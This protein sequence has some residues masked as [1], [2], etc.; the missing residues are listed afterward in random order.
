[1]IAIVCVPAWGSKWASLALGLWWIDIAVAVLVNFGTVF[2]LFTKQHQTELSV[3]P[4]WLL[5]VVSTVV[6]AASGSI[7]AQSLMPFN[8]NLARAT[9]LASYVIWGT[10]VPLAFM[11]ITIVVYRMAL[12]GPPPHTLLASVFLPLG[13]C[14]Q[15]AF[16][17][18]NMGVTARQLAYEHSTPII[19]GM[20]L[21]ASLHIAD[22]MYAGGIV[23]GLIL[24][25]LALLWYTLGIALFLDGWRKDWSL[26][27][28]GKFTVGYWSLTFP[29]G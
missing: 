16:G 24:W 11:V 6:A 27:G 10:G 7:V 14:A 4:A 23:A 13:P 8:P 17:I 1:M 12:H 26:L 25:G 18:V 20:A 15:G 28:T 29:I 19:P 9:L 21:E 5:P 3:S 2:L 22:A